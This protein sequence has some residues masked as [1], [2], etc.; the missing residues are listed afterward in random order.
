MAISLENF[1]DPVALV[2]LALPLAVNVLSA[3]L[4]FFI[5]KWVARKVID[6]VQR[7]AQKPDFGGLG[8]YMKHCDIMTGLV[9]TPGFDTHVAEE[10]K[11][12]AFYLKHTRLAKE[13]EDKRQ[14][15]PPKGPKGKKDDA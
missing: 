1:T 13:E 3:L 9:Q 4:V 12:E 6:V 14:H 7:N 10:G 15:P 8:A 11:T 2:N 5:G